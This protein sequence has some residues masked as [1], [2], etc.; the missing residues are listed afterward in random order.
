M[1]REAEAVRAL[2]RTQRPSMLRG[3]RSEDDRAGYGWQWHRTEIKRRMVVP[4]RCH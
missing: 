4:W 3:E 2:S 1:H